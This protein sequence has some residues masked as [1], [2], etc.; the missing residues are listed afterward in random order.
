MHMHHNSTL[1]NYVTRTHFGYGAAVKLQEEL[2]IL[3]VRR[4]LIITDK[5]V[6]DMGLVDRVIGPLGQVIVFDDTPS[7]P[8][9]AAARRAAHLFRD[10]ECDCIIAIGGG[11]PLDMAKV[12]ALMHEHPGPLSDYALVNG[13]IARI[14]AKLPPVIAIPTTSGTG[15]EVARAAVI[16]MEDGRKLVVASAH[17]VPKLALCDP[18]L[19][20][21]LP[22]R[23]TATTGFDAIAHCIETYCSPVENAPA[24]AIALDGLARLMSNIE[25]AVQEPS[26][27][28][29][30]WEMMMGSLQGGLTFQKGLGGVHA[31]SH[32]LGEY[33]MHHGTL[34]AI[35]LPHVLAYNRPVLEEKMVVLST[36][37]KLA[38]SD[39][40]VER[41]ITEMLSRLA[42][43]SSLSALGFDAKA[44]DDVA[45][46]AEADS[47]NATNPRKAMASD[48][49]RLLLA[50]FD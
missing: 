15:S 29:A 41:G 30:R 1:I 50:A 13:G 39:G 35:L 17:L 49:Q 25:R 46:K 40:G 44:I 20:L 48:Y 36:T 27:R 4:P 38:E 18:G 22:G 45:R 16:I 8:T 31:L 5:G 3:C 11:S 12:V 43:P 2:A 19:T 6:V 21:S 34:N 28:A 7:N 42:I 47:C 14:T 26:H 10:A 33:G 23:L 9:E 24:A 32:P 37:M